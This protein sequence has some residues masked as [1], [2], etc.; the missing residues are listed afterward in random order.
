MGG[1]TRTTTTQTPTT[2]TPELSE[3][4]KTSAQKAQEFQAGGDLRRFLEA[5]PL[6]VS[7]LSARE[8]QAFGMIPQIGELGRRRITGETIQASPSYQ[9]ANQ[10]YETAIRPG[11][12]NQATLSGLGRSTALTNAEAA[13]RAQYLQPTIESALSRETG[14][15]QNE[16]QMTLAQLQALSAAGGTERGISQA[17]AEAEQADYLRRQALE[18]ESV[19][20][21][22]GALIPTAF[23]QQSKTRGKQGIFTGG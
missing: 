22:L 18:E 16:Q 20:Q 8:Q 13:A 17:Q 6:Q 3:L 19:F 10:A 14:A 12:E 11:I 21:P 4:T 5:K 15:L 1:G 9:A 23:G 7:P 2:T